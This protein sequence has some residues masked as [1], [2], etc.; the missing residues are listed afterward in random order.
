MINCVHKLQILE[1]E[2]KSLNSRYND[3]LLVKDYSRAIS[4]ATKAGFLQDAALINYLAGSHFVNRDYN[5]GS[6]Y[7]QQAHTM[8]LL[9]GAN[10]VAKS[11]EKGFPELLKSDD[12]K[13]IKQWTS[14]YR[15]R[16]RFDR[17]MV[18][19]HKMLPRHLRNTI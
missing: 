5:L 10:E 11:L 12:T 6:R 13:T 14:G 16:E 9:W 15:S 18:T 3:E 4:A 1:A 19:Q 8:Y 17:S 7:I 2:M